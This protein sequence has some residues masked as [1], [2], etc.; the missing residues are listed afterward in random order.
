MTFTRTTT[1]TV[2][3]VRRVLASFAADYGMIAQATGTHSRTHVAETVADLTIFAEAGYL[4]E[5]NVVLLDAAEKQLHAARFTIS[6]AAATWANQ[7][8]GNNLWLRIPG[9][10]LRIIATL[11][12]AWWKMTE[13]ER[14]RFRERTGLVGAWSLTTLDTS[15]AGM[16]KS[17]DRRYASNGYGLE[18]ALYSRIEG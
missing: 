7:E 10:R 6:T 13:A 15:Y 11:N 9:A 1:Y 2:T 3:D 17:I 16:S 18:K 14:A 12:N 8:P 4:T 5:I